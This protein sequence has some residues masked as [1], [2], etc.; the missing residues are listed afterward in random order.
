MNLLT[1]PRGTG[2]TIALIY[3]SEATGYPILVKTRA[4]VDNIKNRA[5][6]LGCIIPEP[7]THTELSM[8]KGLRRNTDKILV[9]DLEQYLEEALKQYFGCEVLSA[10]MN[11]KC[12]EVQ[13]G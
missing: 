11:M 7:I 3:T 9:D 4:I 13:N 10:T 6:E 2:K 12:K 5:K 8:N 1:K